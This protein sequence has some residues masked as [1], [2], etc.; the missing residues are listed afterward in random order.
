MKLRCHILNLSK[1]TSLKGKIM[2]IKFLEYDK[3]C[4]QKICS[5]FLFMAV[6]QTSCPMQWV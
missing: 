3:E 2:S 4:K 1:N 5:H 6:L